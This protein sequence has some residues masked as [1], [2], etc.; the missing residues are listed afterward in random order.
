MDNGVS[1]DDAKDKFYCKLQDTINTI[2]KKDLILLAGNFNVHIDASQTGWDT[3]LSNFSQGNT[4][5]NGLHLLSFATANGLLIGNSLFQHPCK[6]Q[7]TWWA[8]NGKDTSVLD[9]VLINSHLRSSLKDVRT[10]RSADCGSDHHLVRACIQLKLTQAKPKTTPTKR[11][12]WSKL[13]E[14]A[15]KKEFHVALSN[16]FSML[17]TMDNV[18]EEEQQISNAINDCATKLCPNVW[19]R[20]QTWISDSSLN[21]IDQRKRAKLI[22]FTWY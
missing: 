5:N 16:R 11:Y 10:M 3:I 18:D 15:L 8:P 14:P 21:L 6:H 4:N 9:Y 22:N 19:Q 17:D 13:L 20:T 1:I 7:I 12:D 2:P